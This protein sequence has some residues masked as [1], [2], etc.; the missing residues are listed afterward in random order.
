[1]YALLTK[2][3][4]Q[5]AGVFLVCVLLHFS[6]HDQTGAKH[7]GRCISGTHEPFLFQHSLMHG[8][9]NC[10]AV[11]GTQATPKFMFLSRWTRRRRAGQTFL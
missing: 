2:A 1:M 4:L 5:N 3:F 6:Q 11:D 7:A 8:L 9:S 10:S